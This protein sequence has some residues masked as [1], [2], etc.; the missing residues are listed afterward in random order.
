MKA[1]AYQDFLDSCPSDDRARITAVRLHTIPTW[2]STSQICPVRVPGSDHLDQCPMS[3]FSL[4]CPFE[5]SNQAFVTSMSICLGFPVPHARFLT[6][7]EQYANIDVWAD[8][9]LTDAAHASRS[10]KSSHDRLAYCL[11]NLTA[12]AGLSSS[13]IQSTIPVAE[14]YTFRRGDIVTSVAGLSASSTYRFSSQTQL[15][16]DV[17]LTHPFSALH[18]FKPDSLSHAESLK[19]RSYRSDYNDKG[20]AF[21]PL[22]CNSF[23]QQAPEL[24]RYQWVVADRAAQR[25]VSR[26]ISPCLCRQSNLA[27]LMIILLYFINI[28]VTDGF[29]II[30]LS[31]RFWLPFMK[32]SLSEYS[33]ALML[34]KCTL[35]TKS[36]SVTFLRLGSLF[37]ALWS[38]TDRR[39]LP[40]L[41]PML[42][43]LPT[44]L[45]PLP[46]QLLPALTPPPPR[47][48]P[49]SLGLLTIPP[50]QADSAFPTLILY[51]I[52]YKTSI[53]QI[54][55]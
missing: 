24:L 27:M 31:R 23:G 51:N 7:T 52:N 1:L 32:Q 17:T 3:L 44:P 25:Y 46:R 15:I 45:H 53:H 41:P 35:N 42:P 47:L 39:P 33:G 34:F 38:Q 29:F 37:F 28:N 9:L 26:Q 22:A 19:N 48:L 30:N 20:M 14:E 6:F 4:M 13:A 12:R 49:L 8:F 50:V 5:L 55:L 36:S 40:R 11:S 54:C 2:C 43:L 16:T 21:A 10:R 18:I